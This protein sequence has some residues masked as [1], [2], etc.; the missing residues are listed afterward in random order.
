[1]EGIGED[2]DAVYQILCVD[3]EQFSADLSLIVLLI[4]W[5][6]YVMGYNQDQRNAGCHVVRPSPGWYKKSNLSNQTMLC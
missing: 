6:V 4:S 1:M 2:L 5:L 3:L